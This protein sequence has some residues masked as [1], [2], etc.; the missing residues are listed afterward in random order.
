MTKGSCDEQECSRKARYASGLCEPHHLELPI[1]IHGNTGKGLKDI[2]GERFGMLVV[3]ER[4]FS[5]KDRRTRW[6]CICDCGNKAVA[7]GDAL[8]N[9]RRKSCGCLHMKSHGEAS[10]RNKKQSVEYAA[11]ARM[12]QRCE[13]KNDSSWY[14]YGG[15]GITIC[16]EWRKDYKEFLAHIGRR[17]SKNHSLDRIDNN[18]NYEPVNVRWATIK[19]QANNKRKMQKRNWR[20]AAKHAYSIVHT[21]EEIIAS[22]TGAKYVVTVDSCTWALLLCCQYLRVNEVEI[23]RF[24]YC[25]VPMS[26]IHAGGKVKFRDQEWLGMYK[27]EPHDI[28]DCARLL[29]SNMY[30]P[31]SFMCLSFH[32]SKHL[33]IGR[34][35]AILC[36]DKKAYEW[37]KRARFDGRKEGKSPKLDK[38][39]IR[40]W[41]C[42]LTPSYAAQGLMLMASMSEHNDPLPND[43]YPDLSQHPAFKQEKIL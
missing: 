11:W 30:I 16:K 4:L 31:K 7:R 18:G 26:I 15:R 21:F 19:V 6:K 27:L 42:Y 20:E 39:L 3:T 8:K 40:G 38:D 13:N 33:P 14:N 12:I 17:P 10:N 35:G 24:T 1:K 22:Y 37:F 32:Y 36:D 34:G 2:V 29:T 9:G 41:H 5:T 25:S 43:D 23:P 28:Y